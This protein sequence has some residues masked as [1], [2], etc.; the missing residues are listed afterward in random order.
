MSSELVS[1][2]AVS[3]GHIAHLDTPAIGIDGYD[4]M[5]DILIA[6][7]LV[8]RRRPYERLAPPEYARR[9]TSAPE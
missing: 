8:K 6:G 5:R 9:A 2:S 1:Q 7:G 3:T 4:A